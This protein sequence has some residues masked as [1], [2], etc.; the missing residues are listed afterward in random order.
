MADILKQVTVI[1]EFYVRWTKLFFFFT[2]NFAKVSIMWIQSFSTRR[3]LSQSQERFFRGE[4]YRLFIPIFKENSEDSVKKLSILVK[5]T[6]LVEKNFK[7]K[8]LIMH[9]LY[10]L[11]RFVGASLSTI[12]IY[13]DLKI[14][15]AIVLMQTCNM[16]NNFHHILHYLEKYHSKMCEKCS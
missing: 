15:Y 4:S 2:T 16:Q 13:Y 10:T 9:R 5:T 11:Y 7:I 1:V 14:K 6:F 8:Y 3:F 12:Q